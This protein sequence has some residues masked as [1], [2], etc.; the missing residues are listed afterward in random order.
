MMDTL[1]LNARRLRDLLASLRDIPSLNPLAGI[2]SG[3]GNQ[4][5][6]CPCNLQ[7]QAGTGGSFLALPRH[8]GGPGI[9]GASPA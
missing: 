6:A 9:G 5:S 4:G 3:P 7:E 1:E 2:V 8:I